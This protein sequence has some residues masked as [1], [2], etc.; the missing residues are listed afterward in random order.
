MSRFAFR[1]E[2]AGLVQGVGFRP[3]VFNLATKKELCGEVYND[4]RGV[5]IVLLCD[6]DE[7]DAFVSE[8]KASLPKLARIDSLKIS[9]IK[10]EGYEDFKISPSRVNLKTSAILSDFSFCEECKKEF[11]EPTNA[12]FHY[13]FITCTHCGVRFS[14]IKALPYDR[15]NT[16]M[17]DFAM[18]EF[19]KSEYEDPTNRRFHA[20]PI[21]CPSCAIKVSLKMPLNSALQ[22][23]EF[24]QALNLSS[25]NSSL[26]FKQSLNSRPEKESLEIQQALN[27]SPKKEDFAL[28]QA[29]AKAKFKELA[30]NQEAFKQAATL[31]KEGKILA[32]KG[33]GGFHLCCDALNQEAIA[34]LRK[35][36]HRPAKPLAV[37][38]KDL[39]Q[40]KSLAHIDEKEEELL[41]SIIKPIVL[42]SAK[43]DLGQIA[44]DTDKIGIMLAYTPFQLLL[45]EYFQ[46]PIIAT[47]ANLSGE[48]IIYKEEDLFSKL[49]GVFDA[50][51]TYDRDICS[52]SDDSIAQVVGD[53]A[54]FLRT[55]RG[56]SPIY[57]ELDEHFK[58][59]NALALGAELKNQFVIAKDKKLIISPYI[60]DLKS[61]DTTNRFN[62]LL[63]FFQKSYDFEF[64]DIIADKHPHFAY[65]KDF[66][67]NVKVQHHYAHLCA[68]LFEHKIYSEVLG[69][70]FDGTGY[71][72]DGHIWGGEIL[73]ADLSGYERVGHFSEFKLI[74]ADIQGISNLALSLIWQWNL[75]DI[76]RDFLAKFEP[77]KL[78]NL[79]KIH[80]QSKLYTSSLGR[81]IDAFGAVIF[82]KERLDY[83]AQI[84]LLMEKH[85]DES[86]DYSYEFELK[87]DEIC[88]KNA[89]SKAFKDDA[90]HSCTGFLNA[91]ASLIIDFAELFEKK[92]QQNLAKKGVLE[93]N[94]LPVILCGGVFQNKTLLKILNKK[95]FKYK[96]SFK[97]PPNDSSIALGQMV[98]F[99]YNAKQKID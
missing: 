87:G 72:D 90:R 74:N 62:T 55:S 84:G 40:A 47:S 44:F 97:Y 13:P 52:P 15:K 69:F 77:L 2:I 91:L 28:K 58:E 14:I 24:K 48:S 65:A 41:K 32:I 67:A 94:N 8:L 20:Q 83:E 39:T 53:E 19:C 35:R 29:A 23:L 42:L 81:I 59:A 73:R 96:T 33:V 43:N 36:K 89:F 38:C 76:A 71:G 30:T 93:Y 92:R 98:H 79:A 7:C 49:D 4:T 82:K 66:K 57:L 16:T 37:L 11:Y 31:L 17:S 9:K 5:V 22:S 78:K 6:K 68:T 3:F 60:G 51:L 10:C 95:H 12:R 50:A 45:F 25:E 85:F 63:S 27:L 70:A 80:A 34:I 54:M 86:L 88:V 99:L 56:V 61:V 64:K 46:S 26:K 21:S 18:C 1:L 75:E